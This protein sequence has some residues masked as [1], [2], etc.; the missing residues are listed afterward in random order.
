MVTPG[1]KTDFDEIESDVRQLCSRFNVLSIGYDPWRSVQMSQRLRAE[2]VPMHE[3][4][5]TTQNFRPAIIELDTAS[6]G[7]FGT[8]ETLP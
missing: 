1:N 2:S 8:T 4:R 3:F 7:G 5:A 6:S